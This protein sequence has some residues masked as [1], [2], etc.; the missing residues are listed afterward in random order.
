[1]ETI[2]MAINRWMDKQNK[3]YSYNGI[4]VRNKKEWSIDNMPQCNIFTIPG[5]RTLTFLGCHY[6]AYH[7]KAAKKLK[8]FKS[9]YWVYENSI[10]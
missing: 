9:T 10:F 8:N 3:A 5:T 7:N 1:M 2:P 6:S 4:S